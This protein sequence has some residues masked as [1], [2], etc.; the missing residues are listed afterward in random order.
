MTVTV[1]NEGLGF[2]AAAI[3]VSDG[4]DSNNQRIATRQEVMSLFAW[5]ERMLK[6]VSRQNSVFKPLK[7]NDLYIVD[8]GVASSD[9]VRGDLRSPRVL[10]LATI[11]N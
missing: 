11:H 9:V 10:C 2:I 1:L 4:N 3:K 8:G 6:K 7:P 5:Q